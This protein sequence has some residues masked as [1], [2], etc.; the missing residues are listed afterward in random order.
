VLI[1]ENGLGA[2][3]ELKGEQVEDDY[4]IEYI[5]NH[6]AQIKDCIG[7]GY[8]V[9]GYCAWSFIDLVSGREGMDKR[10]GFIY[11]NR[12]NDDLKDMR[13]IKKKSFYWYQTIIE[14]RGE[15]L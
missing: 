8:P 4:R 6:L 15:S 11:V 10:Y 12:D 9:I 3:D 1:T 2:H 7:L 14:E 5:H 13:R